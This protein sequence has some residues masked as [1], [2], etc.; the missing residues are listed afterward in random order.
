[1]LA[2]PTTYTLDLGGRLLDES[3]KV[4]TRAE[5]LSMAYIV[6]VDKKYP[7]RLWEEY[8]SA[9]KTDY[10]VKVS[11]KVPLNKGVVVLFS[12]NRKNEIS[13]IFYEC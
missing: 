5:V 4:L 8:Y 13:E 3:R 10:F 6:T 2:P 1:M 12:L 7:D 11:N 9:V